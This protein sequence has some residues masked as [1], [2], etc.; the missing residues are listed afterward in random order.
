MTYVQFNKLRSTKY[1]HRKT[2]VQMT[3][4]IDEIS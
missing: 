3:N 2:T 4:F 1:T